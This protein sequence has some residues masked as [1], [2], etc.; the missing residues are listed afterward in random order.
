MSTKTKRS[1]LIRHTA[2]AWYLGSEFWRER[3]EHILYRANYTCENCGKRP[4]NEVHHL[5]Y[6]RVFNELPS[7]LV[8]LCKQ[9][10]A[11]IHWR[12]PANDNQLQC[13]FDLPTTLEEKEEQT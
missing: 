1:A 10:H 12:Q 8:A 6:V 3:R 4:A 5:T 13:A 2:Y 11:E 9:C 7:D